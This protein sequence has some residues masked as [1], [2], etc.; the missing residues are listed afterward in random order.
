MPGQ[1]IW[2]FLLGGGW[3]GKWH[4]DRFVVKYFSFPVS[5]VLPTLQTRPHFNITVFQKD[6]RAMPRYLRILW[7]AGPK[8]KVRVFFFWRMNVNAFRNS[9]QIFRQHGNCVLYTCWIIHVL[10]STKCYLFHNV[11]FLFSNNT[12]PFINHAL[13]FKYQPGSF[14]G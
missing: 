11:S 14:K 12:F 4:L 6:E 7:G 3:R 13:K 8:T 5:I 1:P 10:L 2:D 9:I